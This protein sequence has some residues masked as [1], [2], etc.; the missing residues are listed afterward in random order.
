M[1]KRLSG[2][3]ENLILMFSLATTMVFSPLPRRCF[4]GHSNGVGGHVGG[5]CPS[6]IQVGLNHDCSSCITARREDDFRS[7]SNCVS[8]DNATMPTAI[9]SRT[10]T[11][12][13]THRRRR[14]HRT[15]F[16][17]VVKGKKRK[18]KRGD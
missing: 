7:L 4:S 5:C 15:L 10:T 6:R 3:R 12:V 13:D 2:S 9:A 18:S 1:C 8:A 14:Q 16:K 11:T 17:A